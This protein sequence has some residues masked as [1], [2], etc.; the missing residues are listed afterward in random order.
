MAVPTAAGVALLA[1]VFY[2]GDFLSPLLYLRTDRHYTL[3]IAL[4][5]LRQMSRSDWPLLM[6]AAVWATFIPVALF[7]L[8]QPLFRPP[9]QSEEK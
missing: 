9:G 5:L 8:A 1:F 3:P 2:W 4:Q 7:L 6:A